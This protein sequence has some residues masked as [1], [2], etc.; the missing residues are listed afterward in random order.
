MWIY[1]TKLFSKRHEAGILAK[2]M[3]VDWWIYGFEQPTIVEVYKTKT[4]K[5][6]VRYKLPL[7]NKYA[8]TTPQEYAPLVAVAKKEN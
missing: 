5:F 4:G 6:G 8:D 2:K 7:G 3:D 1:S